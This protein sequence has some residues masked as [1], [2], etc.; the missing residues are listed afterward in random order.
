MIALMVLV[1][2][3]VGSGLGAMLDEEMAT[4]VGRLP[5]AALRLASWRLPRHIRADRLAEWRTELWHIEQQTEGLPVT[6]LLRGCRFAFSMWRAAPAIARHVGQRAP[7]RPWRRT[8]A[9]VRGLASVLL[10]LVEV[11]VG[12]AAA[13]ALSPVVALVAPVL[14]GGAA[15][16]WLSGRPAPRRDPLLVSA[17]DVTAALRADTALLLTLGA[18]MWASSAWWAWS[19]GR[20]PGL[21]AVVA[22]SL[23]TAIGGGLL[24]LVAEPVGEPDAAA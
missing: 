8:L 16:A 17:P 11:L 24:G 19:A 6:R 1:A 15:G 20:T 21:L 12:A 14:A 2:A 7:L 9:V 22:W 10:E 13:L 18:A 3:G 5:R 4:R 23:A